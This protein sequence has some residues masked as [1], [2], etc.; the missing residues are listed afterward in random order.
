MADNHRALACYRKAGLIQE[1][2]MREG[3]FTAG[4]WRDVALMAALRPGDPG[5]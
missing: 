4:K 5:C 3:A 1:G 2:L